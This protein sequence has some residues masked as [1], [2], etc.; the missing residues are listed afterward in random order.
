MPT[1]PPPPAVSNPRIV[2]DLNNLSFHSNGRKMPDRA[3]NAEPPLAPAASKGKTPREG[4]YVKTILAAVMVLALGVTGISLWEAVHARRMAVSSSQI[5]V[6]G[7]PVCVLQQAG[8]IFASVGMCGTFGSESREDDVGNG[9]VFHGEAPSTIKPRI[10][11][12]PGHP[13]IDSPPDMEEGRRIL[14]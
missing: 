9:G 7:T 14:I 4:Y 12:P 2:P 6:H 10:G 3:V 11:L 8:E 5:F 13:P 1:L